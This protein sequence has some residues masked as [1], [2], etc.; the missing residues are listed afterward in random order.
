MVDFHSIFTHDKLVADINNG[1]KVELRVV[2]GK[3]SAVVFRDGSSPEYIPIHELNAV[4]DFIEY[5]MKNFRK[6][7]LEKEI[8]IHEGVGL[9]ADKVN[10]LY[11]T[12][13]LTTETAELNQLVLR[14]VFF[15]K[16]IDKVK[17]VSEHSDIMWYEL[18]SIRL[19]GFNITQVLKSN[20]IKLK[21][22]FP[23]KEIKLSQKNEALE[24]SEILKYLDTNG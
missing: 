17:A 10:L 3:L 23:T 14:N 16:D 15:G 13:N 7:N 18:I 21:I 6:S 12:G 5:S 19:M 24:N 8:D 20:I 4:H 9:T 1:C 11:C 2:Q 22:R